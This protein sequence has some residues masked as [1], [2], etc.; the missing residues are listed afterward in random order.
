MEQSKTQKYRSKCDFRVLNNYRLIYMPEH[1]RAMKTKNWNGYVYEHI[2][3]AEIA[4]GRELKEKEVVHHLDGNR[5]NNRYE[6]LLVLENSQHRKLH[7][8]LDKTGVLAEKSA[9]EKG[10][11]SEKSKINKEPQFCLS[12]GKTLQSKQTKY[13]SVECSK[14]MRRNARRPTKSQLAK[15][16]KSM[17]WL[18]MG[19]KYGVSDNAVR[20]WA[21]QEGLL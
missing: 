6:N 18:A 13:C 19:R 2:V 12:C 1:K 16:I 17:S 14:Q 8:W 20:K 4:I 15:D 21:R 3:N 10:M 7:E 5:S 9:S 11:N